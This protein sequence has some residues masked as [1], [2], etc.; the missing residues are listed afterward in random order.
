MVLVSE[1]SNEDC[2]S[3]KTIYSLSSKGGVLNAHRFAKIGG[4]LYLT[5]DDYKHPFRDE[6]ASLTYRALEIYGTE[7]AMLKRISYITGLSFS[8]VK[9]LIYRNAFKNPQK[10]MLIINALKRIGKEGLF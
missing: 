5:C 1:F 7:Y 3:K 8:S 2:T 10:A 6:I 4:R 9:G